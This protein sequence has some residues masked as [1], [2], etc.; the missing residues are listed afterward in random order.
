[1]GLNLFIINEIKPINQ[2]PFDDVSFLPQ[3]QPLTE[4][5]TS[6]STSTSTSGVDTNNV[7]DHNG[8]G[9]DDAPLQKGSGGRYRLVCIQHH[10][11]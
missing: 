8:S 6:S 11:L 7:I 3:L 9:R 4:E 2:K 10:L 1:M 5:Q